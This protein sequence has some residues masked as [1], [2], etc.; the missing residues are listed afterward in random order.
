MVQ[1]WIRANL[2]LAVGPDGDVIDW[3]NGIYTPV[4]AFVDMFGVVISTAQSEGRDVRQAIRHADNGRG[5]ASL[6]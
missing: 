2:R 5:Y 4:D 3:D 1:E 6:V